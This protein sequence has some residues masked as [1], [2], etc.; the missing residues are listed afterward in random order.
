MEKEHLLWVEKY[1]P[2]KISDCILPE[3]SKATF[4]KFVDTKDVPNMILSGTPGIGKTTVAR[5]LCDEIGL[6]YILIN[7]SKE[8]GIDTLRTKIVGYAGAVSLTGGRKVIIIDEADYLTGEAQAAFRGVIEEFA[9][10]CSFI[11]TCNHKN[12]II[13]ALHSRC[14]VFD[15]RIPKETIPKLATILC[16]RVET[17]LVN[18][19]TEYDQ[20]AVVELVKK[21]FPDFRRLLNELQRYSATGKIDVGIFAALGEARVG[22]VISYLKQ[23]DFRSLRKWVGINSDQDATKIMDELYAKL[24]DAVKPEYV[25]V[26]IVILGKW[27]YQDAFMAN[28]EISLAACLTEIMLECEM[29]Q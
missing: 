11:F 5:A 10:N 26:A 14:S 23:K 21:F 22:E 12:K 13:P 9:L 16:K 7:G 8:R 1:R 24:S 28:H 18:E 2:H 29:L 3:S 25:P 15:F 6:D 19:K 17:I 20:K 27:M 4:Q